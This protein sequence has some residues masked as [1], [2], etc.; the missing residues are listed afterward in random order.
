MPSAF[1]LRA[2]ASLPN[3]YVAF[4]V[5][6]KYFMPDGVTTQSN[7]VIRIQRHDIHDAA[8]PSRVNGEVQTG[9]VFVQQSTLTKPIANGRFQV[10]G[11]TEVWTIIST[12]VL[13]NGQ[14][15]CACTR[16]GVD[17]Y[18]ERRAKSNG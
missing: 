3:L 11:G 2:A 17:A 18:M 16:S 1:E 10:E 4:G 9:D 7:V 13:K 5:L 15:H 6:S 12:P 8:R 14:W